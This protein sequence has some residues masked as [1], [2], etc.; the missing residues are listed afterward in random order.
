M[1]PIDR[2]A[3]ARFLE[4]AFEPSDHVAILLK[5]SDGSGVMQRIVSREAACAPKFQ[6][7]L[8]A[9]NAKGWNVYVSVNAVAAGRSRTREAVAIV[10]HVFLDI[11]RDADVVLGRIAA[12]TGLPPPSYQLVS[13][14]S[15]MHVFWRV[16]G[17]SKPDVESVQKSLAR[18]LGADTAA[19]SCAQLTR[20]PGLVNHKYATKPAVTIEYLAA[21]QVSDRSCFAGTFVR[22]QVGAT[23]AAS[24]IRVGQERPP[25]VVQ[26]ARSFLRGLPPA[27]EGQHGDVQTFRVC[28]RLVRGF[29]LDD[30]EAWPL[31]REWN[32]RC[33]PPWSDHELAAK[34]LAARRYG[35]EAV[36]GLL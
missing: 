15:K 18:S 19:T 14:P 4:T 9:S 22:G 33:E 35:K 30:E 24:Q 32:T 7:W 16:R 17:V 6:A 3:A 12:E 5:A 20:L 10:R 13:S 1:S 11:D 8:R 21:E 28:C 2:A 23:D 31:L 26:R 27:I 34:L 25:T 36:G 29:A